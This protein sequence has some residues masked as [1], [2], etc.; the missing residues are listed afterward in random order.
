MGNF[1]HIILK[2]TPNGSPFESCGE[3]SFEGLTLQSLGANMIDELKLGG[4]E[5][6]RFYYTIQNI[7]II[8]YIL[9]FV[10]DTFVG[11]A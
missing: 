9:V 2:G 5:K 10:S 3:D 11:I 4:K 6:P 1:I 8:H 7:Q